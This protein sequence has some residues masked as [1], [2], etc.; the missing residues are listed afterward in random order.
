MKKSGDNQKGKIGEKLSQPLVVAVSAN[1]IPC[2]GVNV[3]FTIDEKTKLGEE[4][5]DENGLASFS[6]IIRN[7]KGVKAKLS[8][9]GISREF[10]QNVSSSSI[11][12]SWSAQAS[13]KA[14][15]IS[16]N[17]KNK[18][19]LIGFCLSPPSI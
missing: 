5:T 7:G 9:S 1:G 10:E 19:L 3:I 15:S 8:I 11:S 6:T 18:K 13:D 12:F 17:A 14:F 4:I 16:V 2:T